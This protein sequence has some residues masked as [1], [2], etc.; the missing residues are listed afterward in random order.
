M[1]DVEPLIRTELDR[2]VPAPAYGRADWDD[3]VRRSGVRP[4]IARRPL[5]LAFAVVI[6][7]LAAAAALAT[8]L[9]GFDRWLTGSPGRPA[10]ETVQRQFEAAN[11]RSWAAFPRDTELRELVRTQA[12]GRT[13]TLYGFRSGNAVC[14]RLDG[15]SR[16]EEVQGCAPVSTLTR[17]SAPILVVVANWT[18]FDA[19]NRP[20]ALASFGIA[21]DGVSRVDLDTRD[22][23][24]SA[25]VGGN[26]YLFVQNEP[27]TGNRV[28]AVSA[29]GAT[30]K[31]TRITLGDR[32]W[33]WGASPGRRP[34]G[35]AKVQARIEH[36]AIRWH[37]RGE[38]RGGPRGLVK[39]D[40]LSDTAVG[41][42]GAYCLRIE[43][44]GRGE[45]T[46]CSP[47]ETFFARGSMHVVLSGGA[48]ESL[49]VHG[50]VADGIRR[51]R[52]FLGDG[53]R[54]TVALRHN[55]FTALVGR[56]HLPLKI[57]GYDARGRVVGIVTP[58]TGLPGPPAAAKR[59][60]PRM[61]I[62]GPNGATAVLE[63]G[64][65]VRG[66]HCWRIDFSVGPSP[67]GC[68]PPTGG[69]PRIEVHAIQPAGRDLFVFGAADDVRAPRVTRVVLELANGDRVST[70][71]VAGHFVVAVPRAHL[72][73][74]R[75]FAY[76]VAYNELGFRAQ[77][78]GV[79]FRTR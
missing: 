66:Y 70:R 68:V 57:V 24:H 79:V 17:T 48:S 51:V 18:F 12:G 75:Q 72:R 14:L 45:A 2:L 71:P 31:R 34:R 38:R 32:D 54:Q 50:A 63:V 16:R 60:V 64:R 26:A 44:G 33:P 78:Q 77:R 25:V 61:H 19:R 42:S 10:P 41:L 76:V 47:G 4:R 23:R 73:R 40:P 46:S 59:L 56:V 36:P 62:R 9:G 6:S 20:S 39:P 49:G 52:L 55:L 1:I 58:P 3:V 67:S 65:R 5:V 21:A 29:I 74:Q 22:G 53:T 7:V 30:G 43:S 11:G 8:T 69:G 28:L 37:L 27:N 35:P 13:F 15:Q